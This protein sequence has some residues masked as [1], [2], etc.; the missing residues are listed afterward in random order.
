[1]SRVFNFFPK[2]LAE[3]TSLLDEK[4]Q[5]FGDKTQVVNNLNRIDLSS[6]LELTFYSDSKFAQKFNTSN[7][8]AIISQKLF[9]NLSEKEKNNRSFIVTNDAYTSIIKLAH[10]INQHNEQGI[11]ETLQNQVSQSDYPQVR[12]IG[13]SYLG[14]NT[15]IG[16]KTVIYP[17]T[18]IGVN[19]KIGENCIIY[20]NVS[21]LH[22]CTIG[23]NCI[24]HPG[25]VIGA[26]GFG[27]Y[28]ENHTY[29]KIAQVGNV[30]IKNYVEIGA[31]TSIDRS[32]IGSTIIEDGV[33]IDNLVQIGHN[34]VIGKNTAIVSQVGI[35]GSTSIGENV[36]LGGQSGIAGHI[37][38]TDNVTIL[39]QSGVSKSISKSGTYFGS[40]AKEALEAFKIEAVLKNLPELSKTVFQLKK[41]IDSRQ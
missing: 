28:L 34:C 22:N 14:Y 25:A 27:Y 18:Y 37:S 30:I 29:K 13:N 15:T 26:D 36:R 17:N 38:I 1:M 31:N 32:F 39:A 10:I 12:F 23:D 33:K 35:A 21:I 3:I 9:D 7:S 5:I 40:P 41:T 8:P 2:T 4:S 20:P 11:T 6:N 19:V 24:I 16:K